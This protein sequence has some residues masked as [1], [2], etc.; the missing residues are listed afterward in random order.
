MRRL[1]RI[2]CRLG[3]HR[4]RNVIVMSSPHIDGRRCRWCGKH[5]RKVGGWWAPC[6]SEWGFLPEEYK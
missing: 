1:L 4:W 6:S 5:E 3:L 2:F